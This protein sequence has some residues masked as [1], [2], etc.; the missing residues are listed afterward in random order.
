MLP[1]L[2]SSRRS[3]PSSQ[4]P[5]SLDFVLQSY[6][7]A[8][9]AASAQVQA[10][11]QRRIG[12]YSHQVSRAYDEVADGLAS[13][14][15][16]RN[17]QCVTAALSRSD[18]RLYALLRE[19]LPAFDWSGVG[20]TI[21]HLLLATAKEVAIYVGG[22]AVLG[23]VVGGIAGSFAG[24]VGAIP[25][26]ALGAAAGAKLG[27][28]VMALMGLAS[29]ADGVFHTISE[30]TR[31]FARGFALSWN[32][33]HY[34]D[35]APGRYVA[36]MANA[37]EAFAEGKILLIVMILSSVL[38][39]FSRGVHARDTLLKELAGSKLGPRFAQWVAANEAALHK[40]PV[41]QP[42]ASAAERPPVRSKPAPA[43][44]PAP[45][46]AAAPAPAGQTSEGRG[47]SCK[48]CVTVGHPVNPIFGNKLL[49]G[50]LER[51]FALPAPLPLLWQRSYSSDNPRIGWLGQG[52]SLPISLALQVSADRV[53]VLDPQQREVSFSLPQIGQR[54][55]SPYE[56][57][58]LVRLSAL[59]FA[60]ID[61]D[62]THSTFALAD[63]HAG[64]AHLTD[65][66][67]RNG[68]T[69]RILYDEC[70][71]PTRLFDSAGRTYVLDF[72]GQRLRTVSLLR[73][74][75]EAPVPP[76]AVPLV[77]YD[78]DAAGDLIRVRN[79]LGQTVR[80]FG[81]RNHLLIRHSQPGGLIAAY[82]YDDYRP[83]GRVLRHWT[84][85]GQSWSFD[86]RPHET[87]VTDRLGRRHTYR[88]DRAQRYT[89]ATDALGQRTEQLLD[90]YG[91]VLAATDAA[92]RTT[93]YRYDSRSL[94]IRIE[95]P[96]GGITRIVYDGRTSQPALVTDAEGGITAYRYD[97]CGNLASVTDALGQRTHYRHDGR[98]LPL[99]IIDA[100]GK[101]R[102][103]A[104]DSSGQVRSHTDCA[105]HTTRFDYDDE[106]R[107]IALRDALGHVTRYRHDQLGRLA[108]IVY[109]DGREEQLDY[110]ALGRLIAHV[111]GAGQRTVYARDVDGKPLTRTDALGHAVQYRYDAARRLV[112]LVNENGAVHAFAY[113]AAD[114]L[115]QEIRVDAR[116][117]RYRYDAS[118]W[119]VAREE[120]GTLPNLAPLATAQS[121][122]IETTY[123]RDGGGRLL[124]KIVSHLTGAAQAEQLRS[125]YAYD[126]LGRLV[127]ARNQHA[128]VQLQYD[129]IGQLV[130]ET[131]T[132]EG[133]A[134]TLTHAYDALGNRLQ[135]T[136]PDGRV[137][138]QLYYGSGHLHQ[139]S[140]DGEVVTDLERDALHR[141]IGRTQG[142]MASRF[143]YDP[144]G[145][146]T[147]QQ[148]S[149]GEDG[150]LSR[151]YGYDRA[152]NLATLEDRRSGLT[153]YQYDAIGRLLQATQPTLA[154][155]F[156]FDPA[157]NLLDAQH[158]TGS[159]GRI[160]NNRVTVHEDKRF[161]YDTH[162]NLIDK[163][164]GRHTQMTLRWNAEHQLVEANVTRPAQ[165]DQPAVQTVRYGYDPFG[166]RLFKRDAFGTTRFL[167]DGNRL[168]CETRGSHMRTHVYEP[169]SFVPLAQVQNSAPQVGQ[170]TGSRRQ[171]QRIRH[172]HVDHL[173]TP[174]ELTA[175]DGKLVWAATYRAWGNTLAV[176]L[177][178]EPDA[179]ST[180]GADTFAEVQPIRFQGQYC[181]S[182]TGL[183]Y[184]R[185]RYYDPDIGR[186][187]SQDPIGLQGGDNL[188]Q[189]APNPIAWIDPLGLSSCPCSPQINLKHIFHGETNRRGRPTGFH[190]EGSIGHVD[191]A[192]VTQR[193]PANKH[194]VY[195][196]NVGVFNP[197]TGIYQI[198]TSTMFPN[199]WSR[200]QTLTE[201]RS[202]YQDAVT[203]GA[204]DGRSFKGRS[205]SGVKMEGYLDT[206]GK[207]NTA[208]PKM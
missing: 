15:G 74:T 171:A 136:L 168:L 176:T 198:K 133:R 29:L 20:Q 78:Y 112:Q 207:I 1:V 10:D 68:N 174:R 117:T 33:I 49:T 126:K 24:G 43:P 9:H 50:E 37:A 114:R 142:A 147:A 208:F 86:Y 124:E 109:P 83:A 38:Q 31:Q 11:I 14:P 134:T 175:D 132:A 89:G 77:H 59:C 185:F 123:R 188:Y 162:G 191:N 13:V 69:T 4:P 181:D 135:T 200:A 113:D 26:A 195:E 97:A 25:G 194:G 120:L 161:A 193:G 61:R 106:G 159:A 57:V 144:A 82:T 23:G 201:I 140:L 187:I 66:T 119:P 177:E 64:M 88:F 143:Q 146:L 101:T 80:E 54:L 30:M 151:H 63:P 46:P 203:K 73:D 163:K 81:Y 137:M 149:K 6:E 179:S 5:V 56:Q 127:Q 164:I 169:E 157:H 104:Y 95:A 103:F 202:A 27:G 44:V 28:Q 36:D 148:A 7:R 196:A 153:R 84:N 115:V 35:S 39:Y 167:W 85:S 52:W 108:A 141:V 94:L 47:K 19:R 121:A 3:S 60:L 110:D 178:P 90:D 96:E 92:G 93:R 65:I 184:N 72:S 180:P 197:A 32:A 53:V 166:R 128:H 155:V 156:A 91:N 51:D 99:A 199:T 189:Y 58:T 18:A 170:A 42:G 122:A 145:R 154:E 45:R 192:I 16:V 70:R 172:L 8:F 41:L 139:I 76:S 186:F 131:T 116:V 118:G 62:Q 152:G 102:T 98:G 79:R 173:G 12:I 21:A 165:E 48:Q 130:A 87:V 205:T 2:L 150:L 160:V 71:Q 105:Q 55:Y 67:D 22:G 190:H 125:V 107:L 183:H 204:I 129:A 40:S 17:G 100:H 75:P 206:S 182:E 111:D 158:A 34:K 138:Q